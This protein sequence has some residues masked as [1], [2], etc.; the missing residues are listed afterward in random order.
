MR[1]SV[2]AVMAIPV[3]LYR[4]DAEPLV[5]SVRLHDMKSTFHGDLMGTTA[6]YA[7]MNDQNPSIVCLKEEYDPENGDVLCFRAGEAYRVD[8]VDSPDFITVKAEVTRLSSEKASAYEPPS[9]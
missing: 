6:N 2:H 7:V 4:G 9:A 3:N 8:N 1:R 5:V